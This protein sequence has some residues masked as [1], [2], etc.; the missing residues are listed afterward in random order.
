MEN[1]FF[2][3]VGMLPGLARTVFPKGSLDFRNQRWCGCT[4]LGVDE[5]FWF[6]LAALYRDDPPAVLERRRTTF[7]PWD[8]GEMEALAVFRR[9]AFHSHQS[10]R[11]S[12]KPE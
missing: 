5:G 7:A 8:Q 10:K 11:R 2:R 9:W 6:R 4:R 1:N 3:A 12:G